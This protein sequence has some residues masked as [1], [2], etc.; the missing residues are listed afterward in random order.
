MNK[1]FKLHKYVI[2]QVEKTTPTMEAILIFLDRYGHEMETLVKKKKKPFLRNV[3]FLVH[4]I[5]PNFCE[6]KTQNVEINLKSLTKDLRY[7]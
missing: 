6:M 5:N 1:K 3:H 2:S 4:I 7:T